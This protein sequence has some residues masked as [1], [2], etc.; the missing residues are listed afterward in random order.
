MFEDIDPALL[1]PHVSNRV[2]WPLLPLLAEEHGAETVD[3]WVRDAGLDP[4]WLEDRERWVSY[5]W[6]HAFEACYLSEVFG[7]SDHPPADHPAWRPWRVLGRRSLTRDTAGLIFPII[8]S[9][10]T[11]EQFYR[12]IPALTRHANKLTTTRLIELSPGLAVIEA[13]PHYPETPAGCQLRQG[14][15]EQAPSVW[16]R[17]LA[18]IEHDQ[19]V[20]RGA[21]CCVYRIH[22]Q[23]TAR[24]RLLT[25]VGPPVV[26]AAGVAGL[27]HAAGLAAWGW[28]AGIAGLIAVAAALMARA[29]RAERARIRDTTDLREIVGKAEDQQ[30]QLWEESRE[31]RLA[32]LTNRKIAG[33]LADDLVA[34]IMANPEREV[35]LGGTTTHA[36][37]LFADVVGFTRRC[38]AMDASQVVQDLNAWFGVADPII[39]AHDGI[40]DKRIGDSIMVV[41]VSRDDPSAYSVDRRAI[42]CWLALLQ[43]VQRCS[44]ELVASGSKPLELRVGAAAGRLVLGNMG[45]P[46]K[47]EYTVI[48]DVVNQAAR[49]EGAGSPG[50]LCVPV[51]VLSRAGDLA[52]ETCVIEHRSLQVRGREAAL[53]V[54]TLAPRAERMG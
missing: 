51:E 41:F 22:F 17:P 36:A 54:V 5:H 47:L 50:Q 45:S 30:Q 31:L 40:I 12:R 7:L 44:A 29:N 38:E 11:V 35:Q 21:A 28:L 25:S 26:V 43:A 49:L 20:H 24:R 23:A 52:L 16:G 6:L 53:D 1:E 3:R 48:G 14:L 46:L 2:V 15:F 8:S 19:C 9:L 18:R 33:F 39:A 13:E 27:A 42:H 34:Q 32:L 37:V 10:G 4:R